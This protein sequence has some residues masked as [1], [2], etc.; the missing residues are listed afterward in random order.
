MYRVLVD[1]L[2]RTRQPPIDR[3]WF[4]NL[5]EYLGFDPKHPCSFAVMLRETFLD[6]PKPSPE[7]VR[8][9]NG[10]AH[11]PSA[12]CGSH[13]QWVRL[14]GGPGLAVLGIGVN[15]HIAFN[16]PGTSFDQR[17]HVARL[18]ESTRARAQQ[19]CA[20]S[21][22]PG[23]GITMGIGT[24]LDAKEVLLLASGEGK[25]DVLR[26]ALLGEISI[27]LPASAL[28]THQRVTVIADKEAL[29]CL[30]RGALSALQLRRKGA[31]VRSEYVPAPG[32][33]GS[34]VS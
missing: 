8:L 19:D 32:S 18:T 12:E 13:E 29:S 22:I 34:I 25:A 10:M 24:I 15:G 16:E 1:Q 11:D 30:P 23:Q 5:D 3:L 27:E 33:N 31:S 9:L 7:H 20:D 28:Q 14:H 17:T 4:A 6:E 26:Q 2:Q 21:L